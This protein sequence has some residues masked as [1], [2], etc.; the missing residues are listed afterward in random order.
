LPIPSL[1]ATLV[2]TVGIFGVSLVIR[3]AKMSRGQFSVN[4]TIG[5]PHS[6]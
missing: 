4:S 6:F 3:I 5:R 1:R 2:P